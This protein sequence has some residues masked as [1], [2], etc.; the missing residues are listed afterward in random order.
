MPPK[1]PQ[2][3]S[4]YALAQQ[5]IAA[6]DAPEAVRR[7]R[8][9]LAEAGEGR[10][11]FPL[12][13]ERARRFL[14]G[15]GVAGATVSGEEQ[16]I[17]SLSGAAGDDALDMAR[18]WAAVEGL[19]ARAERA[20]LAG[21]RQAASGLTE[22]LRSAWMAVHDR[23]C[24]VVCGLFSLAARELGEETVGDMWDDAIGDLYPSRDA[25]DTARRPWP[26]SVELLLADAAASLRGH[27]S[28]PG[29]TGEV[30][31][32][33]EEDRWVFRF[34]PCGSGG[35]TLR[36]D[37]NADAVA[38]VGPPFGFGVTAQE[39]D[40]AWRTKGVCLYCAHCCQLQE[41]AAIARLG[42]P[43]RVVNPPVWGTDEP[44]DYCTWSVYKDP[45]LVP[46]GAYRRVGSAKPR[47]GGTSGVGDVTAIEAVELL[48]A[49]EVVTE[50]LRRAIHIGTY[51]PGDKLP[52]ERTL[53]Q[54]LGVSRM[55]VRE[56]IRVL[57]AEGYVSSRR[58]S[59]GGITVLDQG[60]DVKRLRD[61][62][63]RRMPELDDNFDFRAAVEGAAARLAAQ[64]R[65]KHDLARLRE[66]YA[67]LEQGRETARFR[68]A[69]NVF[70]LAIADAARNRFMRQAIEDVRAMTWVP[71]DRVLNQ[72][73][74]S[75]H[76]HHAQILQAIED[77][78]ADAAERAVI[79]H[80]RLAQRDLHRVIE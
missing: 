40:W 41:R 17:V 80:I 79:A 3:E 78:D 66:A 49:H 36:A 15:R 26:E 10:E 52:P 21:D 45:E 62:L 69:D 7:I 74:T 25:Y 46:A 23:F 6:D 18:Q 30:S 11:L 12:F 2:T 16:R 27:L 58:G 28:G 60:D 33:E 43:V 65:T 68:A 71:L 20:C 77:K 51:L 70:H 42:Y 53:A 50:R 75:A 73:F 54:Q 5:A 56:A 64:R 29:R 63:V 47:A 48:P 4:T 24:D 13:I 37:A 14:A 32:A 35:R 61:V 76:E 22:D 39:H 9:A 34:D 8:Q 67:E 38:R 59:A 55:T 44:R 57:R 72:V 1:L 31:L 19:A